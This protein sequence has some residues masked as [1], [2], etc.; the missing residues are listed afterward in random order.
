MVNHLFGVVAF[1]QQAAKQAQTPCLEP[2]DL[3][4]TC[5]DLGNHCIPQEHD[6]QAQ[7]EAD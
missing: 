5:K 7:K 1:K 6:G 3:V 2:G 4:Q